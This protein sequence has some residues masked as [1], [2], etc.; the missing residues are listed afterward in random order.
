MVSGC[1]GCFKLKTPVEILN[2]MARDFSLCSN[3]GLGYLLDFWFSQGSELDM[4]S[5]TLI[6]TISMWNILPCFM[7]ALNPVFPVQRSRHMNISDQ[8]HR[9]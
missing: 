4:A 1:K 8:R 3:Y 5:S 9:L 6:S 2:P 7:E